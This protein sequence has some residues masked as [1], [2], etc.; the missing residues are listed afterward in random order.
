MEADLHIKTRI[1]ILTSEM[2]AI[3][4]ANILY[5]GLSKDANLQARSEHEGRKN[6]LEEIRSELA[7]LQR[8]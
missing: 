8:A 6:R 1:A 7:A 2:E 5:W 4:S 3:H